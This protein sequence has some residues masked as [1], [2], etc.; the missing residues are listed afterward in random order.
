M[1]ELTIDLP[2]ELAAFA[3]RTA[4]QM[5]FASAEDLLR[6]MLRQTWEIAAFRDRI[7]E[8]GAAPT[9]IRAFDEAFFDG[10]RHRIDTSGRS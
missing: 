9:S 7:E 8:G 4:E 1:R 2:D 5:G 3:D 10:L 6:A